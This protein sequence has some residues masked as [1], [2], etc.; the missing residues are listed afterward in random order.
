M[1]GPLRIWLVNRLLVIA[2]PG[3]GIIPLSQW[4]IPVSS[5]TGDP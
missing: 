3:G 1:E 4:Q 5:R 2:T